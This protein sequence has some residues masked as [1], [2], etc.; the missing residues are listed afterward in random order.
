[1]LEQIV[2]WRTGEIRALFESYQLSLQ[3][4]EKARTDR[5]TVGGIPAAATIAAGEV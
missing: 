5:V 1:V 2:G 4:W 3:G